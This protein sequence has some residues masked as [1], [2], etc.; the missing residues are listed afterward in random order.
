MLTQK[1]NGEEPNINGVTYHAGSGL[2][3]K[4]GFESGSSRVVQAMVYF[5]FP[6]GGW[7]GQITVH[8]TII[9]MNE[10]NPF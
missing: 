7:K 2:L 3:G 5:S 9:K 10:I 4:L 6:S 1:T 8:D